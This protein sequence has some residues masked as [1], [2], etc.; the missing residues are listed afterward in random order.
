MYLTPLRAGGYAL[1]LLFTF[2]VAVFAEDRPAVPKQATS[3]VKAT[4]HR[5]SQLMNMSVQNAKRDEIGKITDIVVD[6]NSGQVRYFAIQFGST[7]GFGGK[8]FAVPFKA[9]QIRYDSTSNSQFVL[10]DVNKESLEKA[11]GFPSDKWPD[12]GDQTWTG[13][14]DKFYEADSQR[15]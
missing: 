7:F 15:R 13:T 14:I 6:A 2:G 4:I 3:P 8:L 5:A 10:F 12:F 11:P 1:V 9:V